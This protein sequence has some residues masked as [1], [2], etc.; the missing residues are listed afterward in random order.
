MFGDRGRG[1]GRR[2]CACGACVGRRD[3]AQHAEAVRVFEHAP[4]QEVLDLGLVARA[5]LNRPVKD[6]FA[7]GQ[8]PV[9]NLFPHVRVILFA[10]TSFGLLARYLEDV[11]A[12]LGVLER[13]GDVARLH[14]VE[15]VADRGCQSHLLRQR[16]GEF[17]PG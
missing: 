17:R 11:P 12:V 5:G 7:L 1:W 3:G 4:G 2:A 8:D 15:L 9:L 6:L 13:L 16:A 10:I 14:R